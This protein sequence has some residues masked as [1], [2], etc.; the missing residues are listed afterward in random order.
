MTD[1]EK[2]AYI[3]GM[4]VAIGFKLG[5]RRRGLSFDANTNNPYWITT[6]NG[7]HFLIDE[8][9]TIQSGRFKNQP[10]GK[11]KDGWSKVKP[12]FQH[13]EKSPHQPWEKSG[14]FS[15]F[16]DLNLKEKYE[17][18]VSALTRGYLY[19]KFPTVKPN[20]KQKRS[21]EVTKQNLDKN[22]EALPEKNQ[23][24]IK[25]LKLNPDGLTKFASVPLSFYK[26]LGLDPNKSVVMTLSACMRILHDHPEVGRENLK[27]GLGICLYGEK[28]L[29]P[30]ESNRKHY[31]RFGLRISSESFCDVALDIR[32]TNGHYEIFHFHSNSKSNELG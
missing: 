4:A 9:G 17:P 13:L 1:K 16:E 27:K 23:K 15:E 21:R 5:L 28:H 19:R 12:K 25:E 29:T 2:T 11:L 30:L 31:K 20:A 14:A 3:V 8:E 10:L 26:D 7:H 6:E 22:I 24:L 18:R 32:E